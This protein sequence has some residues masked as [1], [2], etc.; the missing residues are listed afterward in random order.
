MGSMTISRTFFSFF[1]CLDAVRSK[2]RGNHGF[3]CVLELMLAGVCSV[4][5]MNL[6]ICIRQAHLINLSAFVFACG[7]W[8]L[9]T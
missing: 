3:S 5:L 1:F 9:S 6:F 4:R 7:C 8:F 2:S